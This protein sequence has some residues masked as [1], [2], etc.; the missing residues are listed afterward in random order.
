M[1]YIMLLQCSTS[2]VSWTVL[3]PGDRM[4]NPVPECTVMYILQTSTETVKIYLEYSEVLS[5][6]LIFGQYVLAVTV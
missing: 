2:A 3:T 4:K 5:Y 1:A 6:A